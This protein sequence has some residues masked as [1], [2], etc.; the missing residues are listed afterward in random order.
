[1]GNS[2]R[3]H[4]TSKPPALHYASPGLPRGFPQIAMNQHQFTILTHPVDRYEVHQL[5][6]PCLSLKEF[7]RG[8]RGDSPFHPFLGANGVPLSLKASFKSPPNE[9]IQAAS[10][11]GLTSDRVPTCGPAVWWGLWKKSPGVVSRATQNW[12]SRSNKNSYPT[13]TRKSCPRKVLD[14]SPSP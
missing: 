10:A 1:M 2:L 14:C 13:T 4:K 9:V 3:M 5:N 11:V 8:G 6:V 12:Q 7:S